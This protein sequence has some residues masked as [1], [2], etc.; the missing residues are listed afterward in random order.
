MKKRVILSILAGSLVMIC[1]AQPDQDNFLPVSQNPETGA[2][3]SFK[4]QMT[5]SRPEE[6]DVW[7][8]FK[9]PFSNKKYEANLTQLTYVSLAAL[10]IGMGAS[11]LRNNY[12]KDPGSESKSGSTFDLAVFHSNKEAYKLFQRDKWRFAFATIPAALVFGYKYLNGEINPIKF[13][14]IKTPAPENQTQK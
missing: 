9:M 7:I 5:T 8:P 11:F 14:P 13:T 4:K 10:S 1:A 12:V 2:W 6:N 3:E